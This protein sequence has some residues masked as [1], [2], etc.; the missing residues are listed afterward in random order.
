[1]TFFIVHHWGPLHTQD[2]EPGTISLQALSLMGMGMGTQY[3]AL[4]SGDDVMFSTTI[5][6]RTA[7]REGGGSTESW[8]TTYTFNTRPSFQEYSLLVWGCY[9][10]KIIKNETITPT[11][12]GCHSRQSPPLLFLSRKWSPGCIQAWNL[13]STTAFS[14]SGGQ[15]LGT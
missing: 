4:L 3:R 11:Y 12:C 13:T 14:N 10:H 6:A 8:H 7:D 15:C 1:M 9:L 2:W 5:T